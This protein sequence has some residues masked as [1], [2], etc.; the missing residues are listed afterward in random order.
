[1][2][3]V[4]IRTFD[5][6]AGDYDNWELPF[7]YHCIYIL[8]NGKTAYIGET[9]DII[10]RSRQHKK[11]DDLCYRHHFQRIHVLTGE[12]MEATPA[13]H[14]EVLLIRLMKADGKF[15]ILNDQEEWQYYARK[16]EFE[17][18]FDRVWL[19]LEQLGLVKHKSFQSV[20]NLSQYK[21][22]PEAPLTQAQHETLTSIIHTIDSRE[23]QSHREGHLPRPIWIAGDAGTG[24]TVVATSL[25][26]YLRTKER[27]KDKKVGLVYAI[28]AMRREIQQVVK[29]VHGLKKED[30]ISP[31]AVP[32]GGYDIVICD[33]AHRLRRPKNA[34]RYYSAMMKKKNRELGL[35]E[36][37]D[38]LEWI[39]KYSRCQIFFYDRK[40]STSPADISDGD[41][42]MRL[43]KE[44]KRG[45]R[46]I[47]LREQMRLRAGNKYIPYIYDV[48]FQRNPPFRRF[49]GYDFQLFQSF[50]DM[51]QQVWEKERDVGLCRLCGGYAWRWKKDADI[52]DICIENTSI[53]WNQQTQGWLSNEAAKKEVGS[54]YTLAGLDLNYAA[55]V[56]G[57]ELYYDASD[58][59]I[60]VDRAHF[61]DN[62]VKRNTSEED[63]MRFVL[64]TYA[65]LLTRAILGTYV[66]VYDEKLRAYLQR[67]IPKSDHKSAVI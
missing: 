35:D 5:F 60:K 2:A 1:M 27:Y 36:S 16:N 37:T 10:A 40:Q 20:L 55:V 64:N 9:K 54:I 50:D 3:D 14:F 33:E 57:P 38:E 23:T 32:G 65:V 4:E 29:T 62:S 18:C 34:G 21:F 8:E 25:L 58:G 56:I 7:D 61:Y 26:Y 59:R 28:P 19:K 53:W 24:K 63:L 47:E 46:P 42:E 48:L 44:R 67:Y 31:I 51:C 43:H 17:L 12:T 45:V 30:I 6:A 52:P 49:S 11:K 22:A 66:Y 39:L 41:F 13:K 15:R